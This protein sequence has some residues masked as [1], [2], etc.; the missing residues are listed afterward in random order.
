MIYDLEGGGSFPAGSA[1]RRHNEAGAGVVTLLGQED[2]AIIM[3]AFI[4][5]LDYILLYLGAP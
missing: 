1:D 5:W 2:L 3:Y 4:I